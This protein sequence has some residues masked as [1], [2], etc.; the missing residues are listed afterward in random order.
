MLQDMQQQGV[1]Y[2]QCMK[3][4]GWDWHWID[5]CISQC[6]I[7]AHDCILSGWGAGNCVSH[8]MPMLKELYWLYLGHR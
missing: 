1:A 3:S 7:S 6:G 8:A 5:D 4:E 2:V